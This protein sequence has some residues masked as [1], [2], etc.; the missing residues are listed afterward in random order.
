MGAFGAAAAPRR[1]GT[2][3]LRPHGSARRAR[4]IADLDQQRQGHGWDEP[5]AGAPVVHGRGVPTAVAQGSRIVTG[6][7]RGFIAPAGLPPVMAQRLSSA[8]ERAIGS[9]EHRQRMR[10]LGLP[11]RYMN[12]EEF[13]RYWE[14]EE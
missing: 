12:P 3:G 7:A 8:L 6:S 4:H 14:A 11:I 9:D 13:S 5:R 1:G 2:F 10:G